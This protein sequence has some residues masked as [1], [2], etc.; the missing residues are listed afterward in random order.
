MDFYTRLCD[1]LK[2][3]GLSQRKVEQDLGFS[4]AAISKW[5]KYTP[6]AEKVQKVADYLGVSYCYLLNGEEQQKTNLDID[7]VIIE[8]CKNND[9]RERLISYAK[10]LLKMQD[11]ESDVVVPFPKYPGVT[12][13]DIQL[14]AARNAKKNFSEEEIAEMIYEMRKGD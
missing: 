6:N 2:E 5:K 7:D 1:L 9:S 12:K 11:M 13:K 10:A 8:V 4:S 3:K 14:F